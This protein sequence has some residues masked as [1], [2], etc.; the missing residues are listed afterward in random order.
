MIKLS[1]ILTELN[2]QKKTQLG[3][4]DSAEGE[5]YDF[6]SSPDKVV[7][8]YTKTNPEFKYT[9]YN[10]MSKYPEFFIKVYKMTPKYVVLEKVKVPIP[11]LKELQY[12]VNT[13]ANINWKKGTG[14]DPDNAIRNTYATDI[15]SG[16]YREIKTRKNKIF[17]EILNKAIKLQKFNL[18]N[19]LTKLY[20]FFDKLEKKVPGIEKFWFDIQKGNIGEDANGKLKLFDIGYEDEWGDY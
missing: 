18:I 16:I 11:G 19:L 10:F 3:S 2:I 15:V 6:V 4:G 17:N 13:E 8:K 7:K 14:A 1:D 5:T 12:F 9:Q 20:N